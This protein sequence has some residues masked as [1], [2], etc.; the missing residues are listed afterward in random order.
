[1]YKTVFYKMYSLFLLIFQQKQTAFCYTVRSL[2]YIAF[3]LSFWYDT[4]NLLST[5][6]V[7]AAGGSLGGIL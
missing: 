7:C 4:N 3:L 5:A 6:A 2:F 1:M